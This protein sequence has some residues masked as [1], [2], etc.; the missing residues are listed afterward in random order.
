M[1]DFVGYIFIWFV[2]ICTLSMCAIL[3]PWLWYDIIHIYNIYVNIS[4]YIILN[5][6]LLL[7][8]LMPLLCTYLCHDCICLY[9]SCTLYVSIS[10]RFSF[11][12]I[13]HVIVAIQFFYTNATTYIIYSHTRI[14]VYAQNTHENSAHI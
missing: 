13:P 3:M 5:R 6:A 11:R 10:Q 4:H 8:L 14:L 9:M 2:C 7:L 1:V 12:F